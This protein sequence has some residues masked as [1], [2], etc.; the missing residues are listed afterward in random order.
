MNSEESKDKN[1]RPPSLLSE[2]SAGGRVLLKRYAAVLVCTLIL[3]LLY[4]LP[5]LQLTKL[6]LSSDLYSHVVLIPIVA[7][8]LIWTDYKTDEL[9]P[10]NTLR[11][12]SWIPA[13]LG[14]FGLYRYF[15]CPSSDSIAD[16]L[17]PAIL[18]YVCFIWTSYL[19]FVPRKY[20]SQT[21]FA[22]S[23][24]VFIVPFSNTIL[25]YIE[26]FFQYTSAESAFRLFEWSD[27]TIF[28][29]SLLVFQL[30]G[31][32]MEVAAE[33]SGI[34]S[35]LV[36]FIT[37]LIA[38]HLFL[39]TTWK[40]IFLVLFVIPLGIIRNAIRIFTIGQ[41]CIHIDP[42]MIDSYI[43]KRGGPIFFALSLIPFT[44]VLYFIWRSDN[45]VH[46]PEKQAG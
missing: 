25:L 29:H 8:Y 36:L 3:T 11:A 24:L 6:S 45:K 1:S 22:F 4:A 13:F 20:L 19:F 28:R 32:T 21:S 2:I 14:L 9:T 18:S 43:H 34:R 38:G 33:C 40:K 23:L 16:I 42:T 41:L 37:S 5:L 17:S 31:I 46:K 39:R 10:T 7:L 35:S 15:N 26:T 44:L 30:P 12:F 27:T